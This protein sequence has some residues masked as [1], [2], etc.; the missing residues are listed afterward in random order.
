MSI[1]DCLQ[2]AMIDS[3]FTPAEAR[4]ECIARAKSDSYYAMMA[5]RFP[6]DDDHD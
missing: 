6:E 5:E 1:Y 4:A 2:Q 3:G